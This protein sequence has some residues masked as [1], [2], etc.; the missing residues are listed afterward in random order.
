[1]EHI[2]QLPQDDWHDQD[3]LTKSEAAE[4]LVDEIEITR[5]QLAALEADGDVNGEHAALTKRLKAMEA[6]HHDLT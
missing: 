3:L 1:M 4:R 5:R 6:I 2:E